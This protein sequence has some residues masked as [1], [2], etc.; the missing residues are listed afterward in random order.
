MFGFDGDLVEVGVGEVVH[1]EVTLLA[2]HLEEEGLVADD[3]GVLQL[4]D[5]D[6]VLLQEDDVFPVDSE[7]L[8]RQELP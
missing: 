2:V 3:V 5:V 6:E 4:L 8:G 1:D 7:G